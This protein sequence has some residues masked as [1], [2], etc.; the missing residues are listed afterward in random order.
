MIDF[1]GSTGRLSK[2]GS[3]HLLKQ[4]K[5]LEEFHLHFLVA[6][7]GSRVGLSRSG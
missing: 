4:V 6:G 7:M 1:A 3:A 5:G 2:I